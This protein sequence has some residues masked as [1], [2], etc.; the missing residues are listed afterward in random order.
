MDYAKSFEELKAVNPKLPVIVITADRAPD[1]EGL[2]NT[3]LLQDMPVGFPKRL[4]DAQM[5]AQ[6]ELANSFPGAKHITQTNSGHY[7]QI[8]QPQIVSESIRE[9]LNRVR[10]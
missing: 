3:G 8:E 4:W 10:R 7:V 5:E 2:S 6:K 9:V 1:F